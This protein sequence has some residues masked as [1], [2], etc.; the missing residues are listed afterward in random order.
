MTITKLSS[1]N[2]SNVDYDKKYWIRA[3][4]PD[5]GSM[6]CQR[7]LK[8]KPNNRPIDSARVLKIRRGISPSTFKDFPAISV[9]I[10]TWNIYDGQYRWAGFTGLSD[11]EKANVC[12]PIEFNDLTP[13]EEDELMKQMNANNKSW[14]R[15]TKI[16]SWICDGKHPEFTALQGFCNIFPRLHRSNKRRSCHFYGYGAAVLWGDLPDECINTGK[17]LN[18]NAPIGQTA[19]KEGIKR[20]DEIEDIIEAIGA[21]LWSTSTWYER[22][23]KAWFNV[24]HDRQCAAKLHI[25]GMSKMLS[26]LKKHFKKH[27]SMLEASSKTSYWLNVIKVV[28]LE[29]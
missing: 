16:E 21:S 8:L 5:L 6:K 1:I 12:I 13:A 23:A 11:A 2:K 24:T 4:D 20:Y 14:S 10:N 15:K 28:G 19:M 7:M 18:F 29:I 3:N 25:I 27:K 26:N 9:N 17:F 22:L